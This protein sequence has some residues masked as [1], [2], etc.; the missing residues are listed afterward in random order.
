MKVNVTLDRLVVFGDCHLGNPLFYRQSQL[1]DFLR[2]HSDQKFNLFINGD[3][4]DILQASLA[5]IG[6]DVPDVFSRLREFK[7]NDL[8]VY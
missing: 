1:L 4:V 8:E 6:R 2:F 3:L 5:R 7:L